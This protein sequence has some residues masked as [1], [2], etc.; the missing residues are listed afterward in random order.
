VPDWTIERHPVVTA[1]D[2]GATA[3]ASAAGDATHA[4]P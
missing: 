1:E 2:E 3:S 4:H